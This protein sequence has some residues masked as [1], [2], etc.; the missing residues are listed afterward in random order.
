MRVLPIQ[1]S[2][3]EGS[4]HIIYHG[5]KVATSSKSDPVVGTIN[6]DID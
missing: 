2:L 6:A 4:A 3:L 1:L 5:R